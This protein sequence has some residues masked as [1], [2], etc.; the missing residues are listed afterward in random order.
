MLGNDDLEG[1]IKDLLLSH[2]E[3]VKEEPLTLFLGIGLRKRPGR[4]IV[5]DQKHTSRSF[6]TGLTSRR[7]QR[8]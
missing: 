7:R 6:L 1:V 4:S 5:L 8:G 3:S 2:D